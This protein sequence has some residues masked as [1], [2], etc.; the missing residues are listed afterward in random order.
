MKGTSL[1]VL[2]QKFEV[3]DLKKS[4]KQQTTILFKYK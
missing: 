4:F 1:L 3:N 2:D